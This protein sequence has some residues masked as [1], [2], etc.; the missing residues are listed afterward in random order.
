MKRIR[1]TSFQWQELFKTFETSG[2]RA[3]EF[4]Q[5]HNINPK[6]FSKK[7]S[8]YSLKSSDTNGFVKVQINKSRACTDLLLSIEHGDFRLDFYQFPDIEYLSGLIKSAP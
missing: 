7:K 4:C 6:Y 8:E 5:E 1:R 3:V 2:I